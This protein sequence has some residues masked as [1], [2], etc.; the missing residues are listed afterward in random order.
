MTSAR[1]FPPLALPFAAL[2]GAAGWLWRDVLESRFLGGAISPRSH[3]AVA[4]V[5]L[6][7]GVAGA[8]LTPAKPAEEWMTP[9]PGVGRVSAVVLGAGLVAGLILAAL[10][11]PF[12]PWWCAPWWGAPSGLLAAV[13][14]IPAC[15]MVTAAQRR[16]DEGRPGSIIAGIERRTVYALAAIAVVILS[17]LTFPD[18]MSTT[19]AVVRPPR[20]ALAVAALAGFVGLVILIADLA[21]S[22]RIAR[23]QK[24]ILLDDG[25]TNSVDFGLGEEVITRAERGGAYRGGGRVVASALGDPARARAAVKRSITRGV[26]LIAVS[27]LVAMAHGI[28]RDPAA[29][30]AFEAERCVSGTT[31]VCRTA[32]L[33]SERAGQPDA[34]STSLHQRACSDGSEESCLAVYLLGRRNLP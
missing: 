33:L 32:A 3:L 21:A 11:T 2:G 28:A 22:R 1:R 26:I 24:E 30:A 23:I 18:W 19:D 5:A 31:R 10:V 13:P 6:V 34:E 4:A 17:A 7:G 15:L 16:A 25:P 20:D 9:G 8:L 27:E 29:I 12:A 14:L